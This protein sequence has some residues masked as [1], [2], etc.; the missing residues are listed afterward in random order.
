MSHMRG[1][2]HINSEALLERQA[3]TYEAK[4]TALGELLES[5]KR[6]AL[7]NQA[8]RYQRKVAELEDVVNDSSQKEVIARLYLP[9]T[10]DNAH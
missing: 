1:S 6:L 5:E 8:A 3:E 7:E 4:L 10:Y 2:G 9:M